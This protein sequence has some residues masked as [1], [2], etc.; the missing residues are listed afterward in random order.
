M[1]AATSVVQSMPLA[2]KYRPDSSFGASSTET[3]PLA[4]FIATSRKSLQVAIGRE[5]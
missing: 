1:S 4:S 2:Q 5:I 3:F